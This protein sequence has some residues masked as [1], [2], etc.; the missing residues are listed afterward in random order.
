MSWRS[1]S[2][3]L[4][5]EYHNLELQPL[6]GAVTH[7]LFCRFALAIFSKSVFLNQRVKRTPACEADTCDTRW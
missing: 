7:F 1:S 2:H 3:E 4:E 6:C 5:T